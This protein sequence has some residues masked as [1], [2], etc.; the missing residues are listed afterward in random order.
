[1]YI[2][3]LN[4]TLNTYLLISV[5]R[6][7]FQ[8]HVLELCVDVS[9]LTPQIPG[10]W[11]I[12][13]D[14]FR[15]LM[16]SDLNIFIVSET[17]NSSV[18]NLNTGVLFIIVW[19]HYFFSKHLQLIVNILCIEWSED[20][21]WVHTSRTCWLE[22]RASVTTVLPIIAGEIL[23]IGENNHSYVVHCLCTATL[24]TSRTYN[25]AWV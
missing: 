8:L 4:N 19:V 14:E 12:F 7:M 22:R 18:K 15:L 25:T 21:D 6:A 9:C 11:F 10:T 17:V 1:V 16:G 3:L 24:R 13:Y 23:N 20:T 5:L 2:Q